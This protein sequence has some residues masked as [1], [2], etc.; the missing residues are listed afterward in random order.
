VV[1]TALK[2]ARGSTA[3][4]RSAAEAD[5]VFRRW[6][7]GGTRDLLPRAEAWLQGEADR[8]TAC[9]LA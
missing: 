6:W 2:R 5:P 1:P 9:L 4:M 3:T 8:L 7:E